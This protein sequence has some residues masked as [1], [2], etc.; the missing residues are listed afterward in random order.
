[1]RHC[2]NF[3]SGFV[4]KGE[5]VD[6]VGT[7]AIVADQLYSAALPAQPHNNLAQ[8]TDGRNVPEMGAGHVDQDIPGCF[9]Q[10]EGADEPLDR[11]E[12]NLSLG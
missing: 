3:K 6:D 1:M 8:G 4:V 7:R 12:E 9:L 5:F 10:L 11:R 2:P